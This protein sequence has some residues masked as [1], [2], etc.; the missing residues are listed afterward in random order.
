MSSH[1]ASDKPHMDYHGVEPRP[2]WPQ[3][4]NSRCL[5]KCLSITLV[6]G[7]NRQLLHPVELLGAHFDM[8][9]QFGR[10]FSD[11]KIDVLLLT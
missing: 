5:W 7:V 4:I 1:G 10:L 3:P 2:P 9:N 11:M 6:A 8:R